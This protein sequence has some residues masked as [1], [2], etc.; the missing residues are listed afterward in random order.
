MTTI[1][2]AITIAI[3]T[4]PDSALP[5]SCYRLSTP[6]SLHHRSKWYNYTA[7]PLDEPPVKIGE[8]KKD[9]NVS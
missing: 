1:I 4:N 7:K 9:L 2:T 6:G 8:S 5:R 3:T